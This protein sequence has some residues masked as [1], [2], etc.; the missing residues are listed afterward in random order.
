MNDFKVTVYGCRGSMPACG[1]NMDRFGR[2][3]SAFLITAGVR[4]I[5]LDCGSGAVLMGKELLRRNIKNIDMFIGHVH[6]DHILGVPFFEPFCTKDCFV[7]IF[8]AKRN[9]LSTLEQIKCVMSPPFWPVTPDV[10]T[11]EITETEIIPENTYDI[12]D[13]IVVKTMLS[14]HMDKTVLYSFEY[15]GKKLVYACDYEHTRGFDE[16][17]AEFSKN[18]GLIIY[19]SEYTSEEYKGHVGWGHSTFEKGIELLKK[20]G[21]E[22]LMFAHLN[23][24]YDD[25]FL[26]QTD[27]KLRKI[28]DRCFIASEGGAIDI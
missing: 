21:S 18:S 22:K 5:M 12:G 14:S 11:A 1:K 19:D 13:G 24:N 6:I 9:G 4:N 27:I 15:K 3:T 7:H 10:F 17:L 25:C 8:G 16:K 20:S 26:Q 23:S 28:D 2:N